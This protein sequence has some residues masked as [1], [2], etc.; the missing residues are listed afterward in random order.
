MKKIL[1]SLVAIVMIGLALRHTVL[2]LR[3]LPLRVRVPGSVAQSAT[4]RARANHVREQAVSVATTAAAVRV[5]ASAP[6]A[7][8]MAVMNWLTK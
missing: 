5:Q 1:L 6:P 4:A 8:A 3:A 7:K 2:I